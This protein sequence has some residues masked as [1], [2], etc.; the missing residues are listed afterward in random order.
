MFGIVPDYDVVLIFAVLQFT[1]FPAKQGRADGVSDL[2]RTDA[3]DG[4]PF[5]IH[6]N[7]NFRVVE[8]DIYSK[9]FDAID[10]AGVQEVVKVFGHFCNRVK[11][12]PGHFDVD[13]RVGRRPGGFLFHGDLGAGNALYQCPYAVE[14][15]EGGLV[16]P[17]GKFNKRNLYPSQIGLHASVVVHRV[18]GIDRHI[19]NDAFHDGAGLAGIQAGQGLIGFGFQLF[20]DPVGLFGFRAD[21][22]FQVHINEVGLAAGEKGEIG[23]S[24]YQCEQGDE[25]KDKHGKKC[26]RRPASFQQPFQQ[27]LI[28]VHQ[29]GQDPTL[30]CENEV[31]NHQAVEEDEDSQNNQE[32]AKGF[33]P[34]HSG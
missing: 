4:R 25:E 32:A 30:K 14:I 20:Q 1:G 21:R 31:L 2:G 23:F 24:Y 27:P 10:P 7:G 33:D 6:G 16:R 5:L 3:F 13:R 26:P 9:V 19:G 22:H 12:I 34:G 8:V 18:I 11:V 17:L 28:P 29:P 15:G